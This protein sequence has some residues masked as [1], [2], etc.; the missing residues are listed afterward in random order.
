MT[1]GIV[2]EITTELVKAFNPQLRDDFK[3]AKEELGD[4]SWFTSQYCLKN[5]LDFAEIIASAHK[6]FIANEIQF[7]EFEGTNELLIVS[8]TK[9]ELAYG[10]VPAQEDRYQAMLNVSQQL[11][12]YSFHCIRSTKIRQAV[13]EVMSQYEGKEMSQELQVEAMEKFNEAQQ[14]SEEEGAELANTTLD[15]FVAEVLQRNFNK[16]ETRYGE[17]F[18]EEKAINRNLEAE[19]EALEK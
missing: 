6:Q 3:N 7:D 8:L 1:L 12:L 9:K 14:L 15:W 17:K 11:I 16:L 4:I 5:G 13:E 19:R 10:Q 2:E 18:S